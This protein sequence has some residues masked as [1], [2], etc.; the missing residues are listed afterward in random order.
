[1]IAIPH[2]RIRAATILTLCITAWLSSE[3]AQGQEPHETYRTEIGSEYSDGSSTIG[4]DSASFTPDN[5]SVLLKIDSARPV[6]RVAETL[7]TRFGYVITYEDPQYTNEDDLQDV[8]AQVRKD[9]FSYPPGLAPKLMVP[10]GGKLTLR[11][12]VS[13]DINPQGLASIL[14][15]LTRTQA[16]SS[17]G[18]HFRL[19][20]VGDVFH[21]VPT[22]VR[23]RKGNWSHYNSLL[24]TPISLPQQDRSERE[25]YQAIAD[26][27]GDKRHVRLWVIVNG[28]IVV[29]LVS[30]QLHTRVGAAL[31]PARNV[32]T[33][34]LQLHPN[35]RTWA[36]LHSPEEDSDMFALNLLD[37]PTKAPEP[38]LPCA[39]NAVELGP[40]DANDPEKVTGPCNRATDVIP[41][42]VRL[43]C[44]SRQ[45]SWTRA[46]RRGTSGLVAVG[47]DGLDGGYL[48][49]ESTKPVNG[50][51]T[52]EQV[53]EATA[54]ATEYCH[55]FG[56]HLLVLPETI[57]R[58]GRSPALVFRCD[59]DS[60]VLGQ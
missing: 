38:P 2:I 14:Q 56:R 25:L 22:E 10:K 29:G 33:R 26:A 3:G 46:G 41:V 53:R 35:R 24:D 6:H 55:T 32:L 23:D 11:L 31:E 9:Y 12:P 13:T 60:T 37:L 49:F 50:R 36:L 27:V 15:Q 17:R 21:L 1:V 54:K 59:R 30:P 7:Q 8:A 52:E 4:G 5:G 47:S 51:A 16:T 39:D 44:E 28:G 34:A 48:E 19:D 57:D 18:G 42:W 43:P 58:S 40:C 20:Q 45:P